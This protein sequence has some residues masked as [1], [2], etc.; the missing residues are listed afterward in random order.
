MFYSIILWYQISLNLK[1]VLK[2]KQFMPKSKLN[3]CLHGSKI[4]QMNTTAN[5]VG[6]T[7][8]LYWHI[9]LHQ[10]LFG[11]QHGMCS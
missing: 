2:I 11:Q 6:T 10:L 3:N 1:N 5:M 4:N 8:V 7:T 9:P